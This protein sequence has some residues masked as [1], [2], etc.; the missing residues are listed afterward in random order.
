M[1]L[2]RPAIVDGI[3]IQFYFIGVVRNLIAVVVVDV[4][5][6]AAAGWLQLCGLV[7][8]RRRG[9]HFRVPFVLLEGQQ[10]NSVFWRLR[11]FDDLFCQREIQDMCCCSCGLFLLSCVQP[12]PT[13]LPAVPLTCVI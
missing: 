7:F 13:L 8:L 4:A 3:A 6:V 11:L 9:G 2:A 10:M 12:R 5:V 1:W